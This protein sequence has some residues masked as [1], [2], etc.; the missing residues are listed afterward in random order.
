MGLLTSPLIPKKPASEV[1][2][3]KSIGN[4]FSLILYRLRFR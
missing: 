2:Y 4:R 3:N 1:R